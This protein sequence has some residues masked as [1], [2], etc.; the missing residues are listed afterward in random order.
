MKLII[1]KV[2]VCMLVVF[3]FSSCV[4]DDQI[5]ETKELNELTITSELTSYTLEQFSELRIEPVITESSGPDNYTYEWKVI[6]GKENISRVLSTERNLQTTIDLLPDTYYIQYTATNTNTGLKG[7][8][9]DTLNVVGAFYEGW[10]VA[11]TQ[12]GEASLGFVRADGEVFVNPAAEINEVTYP[13]IA[14]AA[15]YSASPYNFILFFTTEGVYRF[16]PADLLAIGET[17]A[18]MGKETRFNNPAYGLGAYAAFGGMDQYIVDKSGLYAGMGASFYPD[19]VLSPFSDRFSGDYELF[20]YMFDNGL[21][22]YF[23]DNKHK[24]FIQVEYL[25]RAYSLTP[26][27]STALFNLSNIGKTAIAVDRGLSATRRHFIMEDLNGRYIY[28]LN[29]I[30]P[31]LKQT[32][33]DA[34]CP[35]FA[36]AT[37]FRP[38]QLYDHIYYGAE[39]KLYLYN[40]P[41]NTAQLVYTFPSGH[42]VKDIQWATTTP[43]RGLAVGVDNGDNGEVYFFEVNEFGKFS[44]DTY[45]QKHEG[46]GNIAHLNYRRR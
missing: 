7:F 23:Y 12:G 37:S 10:L 14:L 26:G 21:N 4:K 15:Y 45:V 39:N 19:L 24:R 32:V 35:D 8:M 3:W 46:F 18:V 28:T 44:N 5:F 9:K 22:A 41:A 33:D 36:I 20:P 38:S 27:S 6:G 30:T 29:G 13:G 1:K 2:A 40:I 11:H 31:S 17:S 16:N 42:K 34:A 43:A 25:D